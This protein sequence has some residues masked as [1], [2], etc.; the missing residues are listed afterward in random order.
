MGG[1]NLAIAKLES[2]FEQA[3]K[4]GFTSGTSH[5]AEL[6]PEYSRIPIN[7]GNQPS[8]QTAFVFNKLGAPQ[9]SQYWSRKVVDQVFSDL[10]PDRGYNGD[11]DQGLMGSLAVLMKTGLFQM[12]GGTEADPEYQLGSPLFNK[13]TIH[14]NPD[15]YSGKTFI[16]DAQNNSETNVFINKADFNDKP[17]QDLILKHSDITAGGV[18]KLQMTSKAHKP[19]EN[20]AVKAKR[21][22]N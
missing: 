3:E 19:L 13:I 2:E 17:L 5:D 1:N 11:E 18:L 7:Y 21:D 9:R 20:L 6:H 12:N 22:E 15:Y 8:I 4:M 14:L 10:S 16:I